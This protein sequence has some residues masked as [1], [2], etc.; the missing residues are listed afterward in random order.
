MKKEV[1]VS[2]KRKGDF[3]EEAAK[4]KLTHKLQKQLRL[5]QN[6]KKLMLRV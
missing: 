1:S 6:E 5:S 2:E 4:Q 3:L